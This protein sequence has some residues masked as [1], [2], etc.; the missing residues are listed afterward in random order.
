V[1]IDPEALKKLNDKLLDQMVTEA[2]NRYIVG[3]MNWFPTPHRVRKDYK[4]GRR[5]FRSTKAFAKNE[6]N[7]LRSYVDQSQL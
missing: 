3:A 7:R 2:E 1:V 4:A 6:W 5:S